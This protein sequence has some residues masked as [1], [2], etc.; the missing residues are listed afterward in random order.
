MMRSWTRRNGSNPLG[1]LGLHPRCGKIRADVNRQ[2]IQARTAEGGARSKS[3]FGSGLAGLGEYEAGLARE[4]LLR[5]GH[6]AQGITPDRHH[7]G[8]LQRV[9]SARAA[10]AP[11]SSQGGRLRKRPPFPNGGLPESR[12]KGQL[13]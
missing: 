3:L 12:G 10:A 6:T 2:I 5:L 7:T 1:S 8:A 13:W 4:Q 9:S 11:G